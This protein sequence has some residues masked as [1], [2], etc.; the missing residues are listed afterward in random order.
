MKAYKIEYQLKE[1]KDITN[2]GDILTTKETFIDNNIILKPQNNVYTDEQK[3]TDATTTFKMRLATREEAQQ[4]ADIADKEFVRCAH[5]VIE[6]EVDIDSL[7]KVGT[8]DA[9]KYE[10]IVRKRNR[11]VTLKHKKHILNIERDFKKGARTD[12]PST[13][14]NKEA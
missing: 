8:F 7:T 1:N 14:A 5:K 6:V 11:K 12:C 3:K 13:E 10:K 4:R 9:Y 2:V